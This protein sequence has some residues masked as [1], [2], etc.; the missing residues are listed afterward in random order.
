[1][2]KNS[3]FEPIGNFVISTLYFEHISFNFWFVPNLLGSETLFKDAQGKIYRKMAANSKRMYLRCLGENCSVSARYNLVD[4]TVK[5][6]GK[7][8][9]HPNKQNDILLIELNFLIRSRA[10]DPNYDHVRAPDLYDQCVDEFH[11][12]IIFPDGHRLQ[13]YRAINNGRKRIRRVS[14]ENPD[15]KIKMHTTLPKSVKF[16]QQVSVCFFVEKPVNSGLKSQLFAT[17]LF[18]QRNENYTQLIMCSFL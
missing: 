2:P 13:A 1:M 12:K 4:K 8:S 10:M 18:I 3:V 7:H 9:N 17:A 11:G 5:F 14:K 16:V 6:F 15:A